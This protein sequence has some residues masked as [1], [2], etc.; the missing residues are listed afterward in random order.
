MCFDKPRPL[1]PHL[2]LLPEPA[3]RRR[4]APRWQ[5]ALALL[6]LSLTLAGIGAAR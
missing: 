5:Q 3:V 4:P 2:L 1:P 6:L